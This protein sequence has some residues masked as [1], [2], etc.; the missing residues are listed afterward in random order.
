MPGLGQCQGEAWKDAAHD[1]R[2]HPQPNNDLEHLKMMQRL[3]DR[4]WPRRN[5]DL[6][7]GASTDKLRG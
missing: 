4:A 2:G 7:L 6:A 5:D 1:S 3:R